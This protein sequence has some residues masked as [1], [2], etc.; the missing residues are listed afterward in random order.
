MA[1]QLGKQYTQNDATAVHVYFDE[2]GHVKAEDAQG[3]TDKVSF[4]IVPLTGKAQREISD[5]MMAVSRKGKTEMRTGTAEMI[6]VIRSVIAIEGMQNA[7]GGRAITKMTEEVYDLC[8]RWMLEELTEAIHVL[9][10]TNTIED[11]EGKIVD[12]DVPFVAASSEQ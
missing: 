2:S 11:D 3:D 12:A 6:R 7:Q 5:R 10:G 1:F 9:N 8:P 4:Y